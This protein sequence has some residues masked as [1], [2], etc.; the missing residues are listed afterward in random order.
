MYVP[1]SWPQVDAAG[2]AGRSYAE[3][4]AVMVAPFAASF[5]TPDEVEAMAESSYRGF[6]HPDVAPLERLAA[7]DWLLDLTWGPTLSFKD[8]A[9]AL[10]GAMM[11]EAVERSGERVLVLGAT[12]G[13]TGSAAIEA[14]R[15]RSRVNVVI[16]YPEGRVSDIQRRQM[17]TVEERNIHAVAID[18]TFDDCQ[19][20]VKALLADRGTLPGHRLAGVQLD[21]LGTGRASD[22]VRRLGGGLRWNTTQRDGVLG[23]D[24]EFRNIYAAIRRL[25]DGDPNR[26]A[27]RGFQPEPR[28]D[29]PDQRRTDDHGAGRSHSCPGD[30][31]PGAIEHRAVTHRVARWPRPS[32]GGGGPPSFAPMGR[33]ISPQSLGPFAQLFS[34]AWLDDEAPSA[35]IA[36]VHPETGR[37]V[38]PHTAI[39]IAAGRQPGRRGRRW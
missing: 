26:P 15:G 19:D 35:A 3:V 16:L 29:R 33:S 25:P 12:S 34:A 13:D 39:G 7:D 36:E 28:S 11:E 38:D 31:H 23:T 20:L 37:L 30:G 6:R 32:R 8:Y 27:R 22:R 10:L 18:G 14:L 21:Q 9:M 5:F 4:V 1:E 2:L 24:R 17:T